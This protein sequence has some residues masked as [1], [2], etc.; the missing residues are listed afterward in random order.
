MDRAA[1]ERRLKTKKKPRIGI[2]PGAF[3]P[4]HAGHVAF[5]LTALQK[6]NLDEVVF[7]PERQP[8]SRPGAEHYAHRVSMIKSALR[9]H[10][11]CSVLEL[12]ER[13]FRTTKTLPTLR[14]VFP[15]A[16]LFLLISSKALPDLLQRPYIGQAFKDFGLIIGAGNKADLSRTRE[17][18]KQSGQCSIRTLVVGH[19]EM[20][21]R[22]SKIRYALRSNGYATGLLA[23]V[24]S[25]ARREWLYVS[26]AAHSLEKYN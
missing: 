13:R 11:R 2:F 24:R 3:D 7:L 20:N 16:E 12:A 14:A 9:P 18:L 15:D 1:K 23:S 8:L 10:P 25:Y 22:S 21:V 4:V 17:I 6:G 5:A 26:A 19:S